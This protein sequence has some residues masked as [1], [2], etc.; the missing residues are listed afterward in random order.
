MGVVFVKADPN[1]R[2]IVW[3]GG[4]AAIFSPWI[5]KSTDR[6][7][8]WDLLDVYGG[9]D[10]RCHDIA[11]Y[12]G[13]SDMA[14]TSME[15]RVRR[16][17]DGGESWTDVLVNDHYLFGIEI[18]TLRPTIIYTSGGQA[19]EPLTLF[20]SENGGDT[21]FSIA[22]ETGGQNCAHDLLLASDI[23]CN[24]LYFATDYGVYRY[25][26]SG[27]FLCGDVNADGAVNL[28]DI[29]YLINHVYM[30]GDPPQPPESGNVNSSPDGVINLADITCLI[31]N[32]YLDRPALRC[33]YP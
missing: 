28:G 22:E 2:D 3:A 29:T 15:G 10:N 18:D 13:N 12:P 21:W 17:D 16:T 32:V 24:V 8:N 9:G 14:W 20:V 6:G 1:V 4:E 31:G 11:V 23:G 5:M 25:I 19:A 33:L 27:L 30:G 7:E 26:D